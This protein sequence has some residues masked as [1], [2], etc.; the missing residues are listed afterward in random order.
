MN[1][2]DLLKTTP[3]WLGSV[4]ATPAIMQLLTSCSQKENLSWKPL[5]LDNKQAFVLENIVDI[6]VPASKTIG[7][8]DV[9][10]PQFI[11]LILKDVFF[12]NEQ[13][14]FLKG[15]QYFKTKFEAMFKKEVE[16]GSREDFLHLISIFFKISAD[17]QRQ[18]FELLNKAED[19]VK[20]KELYCIYK[21][22]TFI[23][24][25]T[26]FGY[27]TSESVGKEILHYDP[28]PGSYLSCVPLSD[29]GNVSSI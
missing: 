22:L 9:N 17:Q 24:H 23:R 7:A 25:Y 6:I 3:F 5:L 2:R 8:L 26:L 20:N 19:K 28:I 27:Y 4:I 10:I 13:Q 12:E 16:N 1:R 18:I 15:A 29:I 14:I 11:D 21:Y